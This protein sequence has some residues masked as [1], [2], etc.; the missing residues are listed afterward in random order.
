[1]QVD[2][3]RFVRRLFSEEAAFAFS[4]AVLVIGLVAAYLA[5]RWTRR[6][7]T[8]SS[9]ADAVEGSPFERSVR[10]VGSSTIGL[11]ASLVAVFVYVL[12]IVLALSIVQL[13]DIQ[14]FWMRVTSYLPRLLIAALAVIV[15]V[16]A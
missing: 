8:A 2:V 11:I 3:P 10:T 7:L 14:L 9:F 12:A 6:A 4:V 16:T 1:M 13:L 15:G 5:W